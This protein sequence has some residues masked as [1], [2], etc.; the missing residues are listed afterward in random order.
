M[1]LVEG[2]AE[3]PPGSSDEALAAVIAAFN[4]L[5]DADAGLRA[6]GQVGGPICLTCGTGGHI[7]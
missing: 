2:A 3:P 6:T 5:L 4:Q 7:Q 1:G